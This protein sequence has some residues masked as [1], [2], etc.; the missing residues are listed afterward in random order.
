MS[1]IDVGLWPR[2]ID[3][4]FV[5]LS[6]RGVG[7]WIRAIYKGEYK[8][9]TLSHDFNISYYAINTLFLGGQTGKF[10]SGLGI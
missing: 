3:M 1:N 5:Y 10:D 2:I 6:P 9:T 8:R 7:D 4:L